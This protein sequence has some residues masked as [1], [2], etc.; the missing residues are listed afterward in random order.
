MTLSALNLGIEIF[1]GTRRRLAVKNA[2][3]RADFV[4]FPV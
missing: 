4:Y 2:D 3:F 1:N